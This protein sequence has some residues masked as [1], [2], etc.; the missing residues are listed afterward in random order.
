MVFA[1]AELQGYI[2]KQPTPLYKTTVYE[3][4]P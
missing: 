2:L 4:E 3:N 1:K